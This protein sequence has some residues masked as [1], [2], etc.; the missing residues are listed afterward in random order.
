MKIKEKVK[1]FVD[2]NKV[3][4][5][6]FAVITPVIAL[7]GY[8]SYNSGCKVGYEKGI[9]N[10]VIHGFNGAISWFDGHYNTGLRAIQDT[11]LKTIP[12]KDMIG[13]K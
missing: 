13:L 4:L 7:T 2:D 8:Y 12:E 5:T 10:G 1:K 11:Y 3:G 9:H 6:V